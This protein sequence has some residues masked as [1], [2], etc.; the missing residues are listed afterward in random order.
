[1]TTSIDAELTQLIA[2][3][4]RIQDEVGT[5]DGEK[6][7]L[8]RGHGVDRFSDLRNQLMDK[9]ADLKENVDE[10]KR[11]ESKPA[12]NP[13]EVI[14][15]QA[16]IR[17][18]LAIVEEDWNELEGIYKA[19]VMKRKSKLTG[20]EKAARQKTLVDLQAEIQGMYCILRIIT[21]FPTYLPL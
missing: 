2:K 13:R 18:D 14:A 7:K 5:I 12:E 10:V 4:H 8:R 15:I 11:L 20:E 17:G 19:E 1:M 3:L 16:K 6:K 9:L 21:P